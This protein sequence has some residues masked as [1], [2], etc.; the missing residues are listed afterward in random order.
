MKNNTSIFELQEKLL[1]LKKAVDDEDLYGMSVIDNPDEDSE[2]DE[3]SQWLNQQ[4]EKANISNYPSNKKWKPS[5]VSDTKQA[6]IDRAMKEGHT[7]KEAH[8][9]AGEKVHGYKPEAHSSKVF[10]ILKDAAK[11]HIDNEAYNARIDASESINP[12]KYTEGR[13]IDAFAHHTGDYKAAYHAK[14]QDEDLKNM[15]PKDRHQHL[16]DWKIEQKKGDYH[17]DIRATQESEQPTGAAQRRVTPLQG[18]QKKWFDY[19]VQEHMPEIEK[20]VSYLRAKGQVPPNIEHGD[21]VAHGV[22]GLMD[23]LSRY[24]EGVASRTYKE[25]ANPF[26]KY[27]AQRIRGKM[28]DHVKTERG[29]KGDSGGSG[30]SAAEAAQHLGLSGEGDELPGMSIKGGSDA[31]SA[32]KFLNNDQHQRMQAVKAAKATMQ[33]KTVIRRRPQ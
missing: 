18:A 33:P 25:G 17:K 27:A 14:L 1:K 22:N 10:G 5:E 26:T 11:Q 32:H 21:M 24:D 2:E 30:F 15:S 19:T 20:N 31:P 23:A 6:I 13:L 12:S 4:H 8:W 16:R 3:A 9:L 7:E 29:P 28:L